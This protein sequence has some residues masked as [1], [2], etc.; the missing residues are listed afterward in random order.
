MRFEIKSYIS[1]NVAGASVT[2]SWSAPHGNGEANVTTNYGGVATASIPLAALL[3]GEN[4]TL[5][6][7]VLSVR[8]AG[9]FVCTLF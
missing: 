4:V 1:A 9:L 3:R 2:Y 8:D 6:G 5:P 7:D